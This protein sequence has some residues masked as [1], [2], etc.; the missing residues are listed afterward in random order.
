[1]KARGEYVQSLVEDN[2]WLL[3]FPQI[4]S[5][6]DLHDGDYRDLKLLCRIGLEP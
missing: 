1:M 5:L 6:L 4:G 2:G 3:I